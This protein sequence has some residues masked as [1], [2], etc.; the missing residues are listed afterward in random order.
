M[1]IVFSDKAEVEREKNESNSGSIHYYII[2]LRNFIR[3]VDEIL[4]I[5]IST[6]TLVKVKVAGEPPLSQRYHPNPATPVTLALAVTTRLRD[7]RAAT[8]EAKPKPQWVTWP[9]VGHGSGFP[10]PQAV[11]PTDI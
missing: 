4:S 11:L 5:L 1:L 3:I 6:W 10:L 2:I 9:R 8:L 7:A